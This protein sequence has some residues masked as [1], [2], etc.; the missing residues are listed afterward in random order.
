MPHAP[1]RTLSST[2][3]STTTAVLVFALALSGC[4]ALRVREHRHPSGSAVSVRV[5]WDD[6]G[7]SRLVSG[8][9]VL[10]T[11]VGPG[12]TP[13]GP[14][15]ELSATT[16]A[17]AALFFGE[18]EPGRY[19]VALSAPGVAEVARTFELPPDRRVS[20]R[21]DVD[22]LERTDALVQEDPDRSSR[23]GDVALT[24][25]KGIGIA[26]V[27]ITVVGI[28]LIIDGLLDDD[29]DDDDDDD[30]AP[31]SGCAGHG[32]WS[33]EHPCRCTCHLG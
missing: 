2:L 9:R 12:A 25:L 14:S 22:A 21:V 16:N 31:C 18:L 3:R 27:V 1:L 20:V 4:G 15:R 7:A 19:R 17:H 10:L 30:D 32:R 24:V 28:F 33:P 26:L 8:V 5:V 11:R 23:A 13:P 6:D 29:C